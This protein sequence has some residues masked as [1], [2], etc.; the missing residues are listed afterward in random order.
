MAV[1]AGPK[2]GFENPHEAGHLDWLK[3]FING[4][5]S[6]FCLFRGKWRVILRIWRMLDRAFR[7]YCVDD[8]RHVPIAGKRQRLLRSGGCGR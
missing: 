2:R 5:Q 7:P 1:G 8:G 4:M 6:G 3:W